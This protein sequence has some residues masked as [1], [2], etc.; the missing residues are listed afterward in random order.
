MLE[1]LKNFHGKVERFFSSFAG[2][3]SLPVVLL[4]FLFAS[5]FAGFLW[6]GTE[7]RGGLLAGFE[8]S[9][10]A[11]FLSGL[12]K[13]VLAGV[14][15]LITCITTLFSGKLFKG[16][17]SFSK[18]LFLQSLLFLFGVIVLASLLLLLGVVFTKFSD[19]IFVGFAYFAL[20]VSIALFS[21]YLQLAVIKAIHEI[22][23]APAGATF[24]V[25]NLVAPILFLIA[26]AVILALTP[27]SPYYEYASII[28]NDSSGLEIL[29]NTSHGECIFKVPPDWRPASEKEFNELSKIDRRLYGIR[30]STFRVFVNSNLNKSAHFGFVYFPPLDWDI[31]IFKSCSRLQREAIQ[32][33]IRNDFTIVS[34]TYLEINE[35][36]S[37]TCDVRLIDESKSLVHHEIYHSFDSRITAGH[38]AYELVYQSP[39]KYEQNLDEMIRQMKC[40]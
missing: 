34:A 26:F 19:N 32:R 6:A 39:I 30:N 28:K 33:E 38:I 36:N 35:T 13:S 2:S 15:V 22:E 14:L 27:S 5:L 8:K 4:V 23:F 29:Y 11:V 10:S 3:V 7:F 24:V 1:L 16:R 25:T 37:Q 40:R 17:G 9:F 21:L 31:D 12:Q 18:L 20:S